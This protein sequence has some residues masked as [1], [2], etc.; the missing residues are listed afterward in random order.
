[1]HAISAPQ[2][3]LTSRVIIQSQDVMQ[4]PQKPAEADR[5][6]RWEG[7]LRACA[8]GEQTALSSLYDESSQL[9]YTI[10]YRVLGNRDDADEVTVDV[11]RQIWRD[12]SRFD[13]NRGSPAAWVT[14]LARSRAMDRLRSRQIRVRVERQ[15]PE[16][17]VEIRD[18]APDPERTVRDNERSAKM[19]SA[20][21]QLPEQQRKVIE[22]AFFDGLSHGDISARLAIPL[23]TAK[24]RI[25]MAMSKLRGLL[26][27][28]L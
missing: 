23:G 12:S 15:L 10:A 20:L 2:N 16:S 27:E 24:T 7:Y 21:A 22:L 1:M 19:K 6:A 5:S 28:N 4:S 11:Y 8:K 14:V 9:V 26:E 3:F 18:Q 13:L 25:R 17:A